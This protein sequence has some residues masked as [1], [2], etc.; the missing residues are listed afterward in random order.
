[1]QVREASL[2]QSALAS[3]IGL[4]ASPEP[5]RI[6][7]PKWKPAAVKPV[8]QTSEPEPTSEQESR[9][10]A[11]AT[12]PEHDSAAVVASPSEP[13]K[14][15]Q[16]AQATPLNQP[17]DHG[18]AYLNK[19]MDQLHDSPSSFGDWHYL[20]QGVLK[21]I[22]FGIGVEHACV[23]LPDKQRTSM[24][25]VYGEQTEGLGNLSVARIPLD[26]APLFRQLMKK[27]AAVLITAA[28]REAYLKGMPTALANALPEQ[29]MLMSITAGNSPIGVVVAAPP[30]GQC[31]DE[32]QYK[33]FRQL[34]STT[35]QSLVSLRKLSVQRQAQRRSMP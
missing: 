30:A 31:L 32:Q 8:K 29:M 33:R 5:V 3:G 18:R 21:G 25:M 11:D 35:S 17:A 19:L 12:Q 2:R 28:N 4:L 1:V 22:R 13:E 27:R 20:M 14:S 6:S 26:T 10:V 23:L 15:E 16:S 24:R 34:C 9:P 7:Y